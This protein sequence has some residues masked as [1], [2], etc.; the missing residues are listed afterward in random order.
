MQGLGE[1]EEIDINLIIPNKNINIQNG[2]I[3][4]IGEYK[5]NWIFSQLEVIGK[6]YNFDL[7]TPIKEISSTAMNVILFGKKE[8]F[9]I[10][11][12]KIGISKKYEI[13]FEG[14]ISFIDFQYKNANS[15]RITKWAKNSTKK[16]I[17]IHV[18]GKN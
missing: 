15:N 7:K 10:K 13:D 16:E 2:G 4:P 17:A 11:N 1:I 14:I 12:S 18:R 6:K 3:L 9:K 8:S 5:N